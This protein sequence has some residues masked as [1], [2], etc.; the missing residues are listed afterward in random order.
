MQDIFLSCY[1]AIIVIHYDSIH[2]VYYYVVYVVYLGF[3]LY[4]CYY[5]CYCFAIID[6]GRARDG[7]VGRGKSRSARFPTLRSSGLSS[8]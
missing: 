4:F 7:L 2:V 3:G 6:G 5:E 8:F 1:Y